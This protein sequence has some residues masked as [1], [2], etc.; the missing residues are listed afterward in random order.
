ME[1]VLRFARR[2]ALERRADTLKSE[3]AQRVLEVVP[4]DG[5]GAVRRGPEGELELVSGFG[6]PV[7]R[8]WSWIASCAGRVIADGRPRLF[9]PDPEA[10]RERPGRGRLL[11]V[12]FSA[13]Q[14]RGALFV[15]RLNTVDILRKRD[16]EPLWLASI[17][18]GAMLKEGAARLDAQSCAGQLGALTDASRD[19]VLLLDGAGRVS[20]LNA[21]AARLLDVDTLGVRGRTLN[22]S[23]GLGALQQLVQRKEDAHK[24]TSVSLPG[25]SARVRVRHHGHGIVF[26][27]SVEKPVEQRTGGHLARYS[28]EDFISQDPSVLSALEGARQAARTE[29]S[30]LITGESGVGKELMAQA[31]HAA[32]MLSTGPFVA[33]N[34]AAIPAELLES[35]LFGYEAG[36][37]TGAGMQGKPGKFEQ[38]SGGTLL[39][40]EIGEM[41]AAMQ[42][43]LLRV[44]QERQVQR[45]GGVSTIPVRAR[46]LATTNRDLRREVK[47]GRFRLD[48]Y[49][50]LRVVEVR[51][52]PLRE[53][54]GDVPLLVEHFLAQHCKQ[55]DRGRVTVTHA[56][57]DQL[58]HHRWIGNVRELSNLLLGVI[59]LLPENVSVIDDL[60]VFLANPDL[61]PIASPERMIMP[62]GR[63]V[64]ATPAKSRREVPPSANRPVEPLAVVEKRA[65]SYAL[66][67]L[68]RNMSKVAKA[69]GVSRTTLYKKVKDYEL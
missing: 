69:L 1:E 63:R 59:S 33:V 44:L 53:R 25:G 48:L 65:I 41:K 20:L 10:A 15:T 51:L 21:V 68:D 60:P 16:V 67:K 18:G 35:E 49:H 28:F 34:V 42:A 40:D 27:F 36:A 52:P 64:T 3:L 11:V 29:V 62:G 55:L 9:H 8:R 37:F 13:G 4:G 50:R 61:T 14:W 12:P 45:L 22:E 17:L 66:S 58:K 23:P 47:A 6:P 54:P 43:K 38:A 39:L 32:S 5:A 31:V 30:V 57:M 56:V 19:G 26:L 2:L 7:Q 46:V 24:I